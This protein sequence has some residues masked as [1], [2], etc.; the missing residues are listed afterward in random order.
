MPVYLCSKASKA[1]KACKHGTVA[2]A[3]ATSCDSGNN[4]GCL[5]QMQGLYKLHLENTS[6]PPNY[7]QLLQL[8]DMLDLGA[9]EAD[10]LEADVMTNAATFSI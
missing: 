9:S 4:G 8:R 10:Q 5:L 1:I 2:H 3:M 7:A 6:L